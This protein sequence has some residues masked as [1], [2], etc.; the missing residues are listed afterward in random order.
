MALAQSRFLL[1]V[2][3]LLGRKRWQRLRVLFQELRRDN[4]Q[5]RPRRRLS[6]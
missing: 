1:E 5:R 6:N 3:Q 2:R 4:P